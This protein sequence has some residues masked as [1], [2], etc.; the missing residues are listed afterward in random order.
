MSKARVA[1]CVCFL[2]EE[3]A[4]P[5]FLP[6]L[7][8][9]NSTSHYCWQQAALGAGHGWDAGDIVDWVYQSENKEQLFLSK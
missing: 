6:L 4:S 9:D 2:W 7:L 1:G 8:K 5:V 3:G